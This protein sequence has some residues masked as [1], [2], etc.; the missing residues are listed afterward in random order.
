MPF[1]QPKINAIRPTATTGTPDR[2]DA[3]LV[4]GA[5][6]E[7][8]AQLRS[9]VG[10]DQVLARATDLVKYA[11]D[12]S[13]YRLLPQAVVVARNATD[14]AAVFEVARRS[15]RSLVFRA[16]GTSLSGQAQSDDLL[17]DVRRHWVGVEVLDDGRRVRVRPGSTVGQVNLSLRS[18][19]RML[20]PDPA[21]SAV[22]CV[23]GVVANNSSGMAAGTAH[24]S[25]TTVSCMTFVLPNGAVINTAAPDA[26]RTFAEAAPELAAGLT[27]IKGEIESDAALVERIRRKYS[28]KNTNG[29]RLDAFLDG[30]TPLDI[31]RRLI[32]GS[33]GTLAFLAEVVFDT[34]PFGRRHTTALLIFPTLE[35]GAAAVPAFVDA[36]AR[37]VEMMDANTLRLSADK[38]GAPESWSRLPDEACGL[39]VE[40]RAPDAASLAELAAKASAVV[41]GL[42]LWEPA[43]FTSDDALAGFFWKVR[44]NLMA[45]LGKNRPPETALIVED[46]CVPPVRI[47]E[48]C[49]DV[50]A[51][52]EKYGYPKGIAGHASAGNLHFIL[53]FDAK[54]DADRQRY[55]GFMDELVDL[56]VHTYDGS[57]KAEHGTGRNMSP[58]LETEWGAHATDLMWR[59][60]SLADP[61]GLLAPGVMLNRDPHANMANLK[62]MPTIE[63]GADAC[64]ECGF[65]EQV[66]PSRD[67]TTTPRQRIALRREMFRQPAGSDLQ[68][69]LVREYDYDAVQSCAGDGTCSL[70]CPVD[71]DTGALMKQFRSANHSPREETVAL[72]AAR[73]WSTVERA[74]RLALAGGGKVGHRAMHALTS[75]ART[76]VSPELFPAWTEAMPKP[77]ARLPETSR[78]GAAAVYFPACINRIFG[79]SHH[80]DRE[81]SLPEALIAVSARAEMPLWIP[82]DVQG[83]C[84]GTVWRSKGYQEGNLYMAREVVSR[85]WRWTDGGRLP[86]VVDASSCTLGLTSELVPYLDRETRA[87]HEQITILDSVTWGYEKLAAVLPIKQPV[88]SVAVHATCSMQHLG[89]GEDLTRLAALVADEV[90][91]PDSMTCCGFAGDRGLLHPELTAAATAAEAAEIRAHGAAAHVSANRTCEVAMEQ[92]TGEVYESVILLLERSSRSS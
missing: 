36:G 73:Q 52:L 24:N 64:F 9:A 14:V 51:L 83:A 75:F 61:D 60:K 12:A 89:L 38:P 40:F 11:T 31:F 53:A 2:L 79:H 23:G 90:V 33:Q 47:A 15:K 49:R 72:A 88:K 37:A 28:I 55:A 58:Y 41:D 25:Y 91:V 22:A 70:A 50:L 85:L 4:H 29:Y 30:D 77:A 10:D 19:G 6:S 82:D 76:V 87:R 66:C 56:I 62:T 67:L 65:C 78:A 46:V 68:R 18:Y 35:E 43:E 5:P 42:A 48:G 39:L 13:P 44:S 17:V 57:L 45:G 86:V 8:L 26:E 27:E 16:G 54:S 59:I 21:S 92:A 74:A 1:L 3:D 20:G 80:S 81:L 84:C 69:E 63:P 34:V 71:I 32:V 7:L